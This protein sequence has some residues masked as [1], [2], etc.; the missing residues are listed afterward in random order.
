MSSSRIGVK[1]NYLLCDLLVS[2]CLALCHPGRMIGVACIIVS[3]LVLHIL[4]IQN[5]GYHGDE[6]YYLAGTQ[7]LD[8]GYVDHPPLAVW[9]LGFIRAVF[10]DSLWAVR[11]VPLL[12]GATTIWLTGTMARAMGGGGFA[13]LVAATAVMI[14]GI[15]AAVASFYTL[16]SLDILWWALAQLLLIRLIDG[17]RPILWWILG[18]VMGLGLLTK[19]SMLWFGLGLGVAII[20]TPNR[21]WLTQTQPWLA[22]L[23]TFSIST[24]YVLWQVA[25]DWVTWDWMLH[26]SN[27][28]LRDASAAYFLT[29]QILATHP[30]NAPLWLGGLGCLL[31]APFLSRYRLLGIQAATVLILLGWA[32]PAIVHYPGPVY[33]V[34]F[35]AGSVV[36]ERVTRRRFM[37]LI[38]RPAAVG[39]MLFAGL[40]GLPLA[41][42]ILP[43]DEV[44]AYVRDLGITAPEAYGREHHDFPQQFSTMLGWPETVA[45]TARAWHALPES[46]RSR[47][48]ILAASYSDAGAVDLFGPRY[49][50]PRSISGH[51]SYWLW[52]KRDYDLATVLAVGYPSGWLEPYW[53]E[54]QVVEIVRCPRCELWRQE[55]E[56]VFARK[57]K[58]ST[59]AIWEAQRHD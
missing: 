26:G 44:E 31:F 15:H 22:A 33:A 7:H 48:A 46:E 27:A 16:N 6:L 40:V 20:A 8:W 43:E 36:L 58:D 39:L 55:I 59:Q 2:F 14:S 47:V 35:A 25:H 41:I 52:G 18:I 13:A 54:V 42:P 24:P 3:A 29:N 34:L 38:L 45:A 53:D 49:G 56:I 9:V 21:R 30:I 4:A 19:L 28:V 50:L 23:I 32:A 37:R 5:Y 12:A 17:E 51:N 1:T 10:G 57:P 11:A